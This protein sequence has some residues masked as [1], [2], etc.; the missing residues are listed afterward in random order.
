MPSKC[1]TKSLRRAPK[2]MSQLS[3]GS[4]LLTQNHIS[5]FNPIW[6]TMVCRDM[7][8]KSDEHHPGTV[9]LSATRISAA[10]FPQL[11]LD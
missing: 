6:D 10:L 11:V 2:G 9:C 5:L 7:A 4:R 1:E 8:A 3:L